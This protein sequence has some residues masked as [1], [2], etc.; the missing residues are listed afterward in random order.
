MSLTFALLSGP[1]WAAGP[2]TVL[3]ADGGVDFGGISTLIEDYATEIQILGGIL[4]VMAML[5]IGIRIGFSSASSNQGVRQGIGALGGVALGA[6]IVG[7]AFVVTP[8]LTG[9]A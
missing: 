7:L 9:G 8:L 2:T 6:V 4:L 3:A 1:P 5:V